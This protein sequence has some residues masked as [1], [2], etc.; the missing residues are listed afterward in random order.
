LKETS[1]ENDRVFDVSTV[2][3]VEQRGKDPSAFY[4]LDPSLRKRKRL[5]DMAKV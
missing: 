2:L 1:D 5:R 3:F 4:T